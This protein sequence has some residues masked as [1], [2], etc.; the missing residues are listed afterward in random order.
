MDDKWLISYFS[1]ALKCNFQI[2][3]VIDCFLWYTFRPRAWC[4]QLDLIR[5]HD[6]SGPASNFVWNSQ[7]YQP[8]KDANRFL[9]N[10]LPTT[11][12]VNICRKGTDVPWIRTEAYYASGELPIKIPR[13]AFVQ[14]C[15]RKETNSQK[16][17]LLWFDNALTQE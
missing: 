11:D 1:I 3:K 14:N 9:E 10:M 8:H 5:K 16:E 4:N 13:F 12:T 17:W 6:V 7:T 15:V 2:V